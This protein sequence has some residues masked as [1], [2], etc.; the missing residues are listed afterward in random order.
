MPRF[1]PQ[2]TRRKGFPLRTD[3]RT[4][5]WA[6][7]D[8]PR[9]GRGPGG[10]PRPNGRR[11]PCP[12]RP[13]PAA[14]PGAVRLESKENRPWPASMNCTRPLPN[15]SPPRWRRAR[16]PGTVPGPS[17]PTPKSWKPLRENAE[18]YRGINVLILWGAAIDAGHASPFWMTYRQA[19]SIGAQVR[20]GE[21]A[22]HI[23]LRQDG[24]APGDRRVGRGDRGAAAGPPR[25]RGVQRRP[26]RRPAG[27]V[28]ARDARRQPRRTRR[29]LPGV[30]RR[31]GYR[32]PLR[33]GSA[34]TTPPAPTASRCRRSRP[35]SPPRRSTR[36]CCTN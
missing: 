23:V 31:P 6:A 24:Q 22:T 21:K 8:R 4:G 11:R 27:E 16:C 26:D 3:R 30:D 25:L 34:P 14:G 9:Q 10:R 12:G 35:S 13:S 20:R 1:G 2:R 29:R 7:G 5:A 17:T 15:K 18:P 36:P 28:R 32:H 33:A 19:Q